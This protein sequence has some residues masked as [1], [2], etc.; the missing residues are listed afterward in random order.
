MTRRRQQRMRAIPNKVLIHQA[1]R[2]ESEDDHPDT[3]R[4]VRL[5]DLWVASSG[6]T[7]LMAIVSLFG[8]DT[9]WAV[10][11]MPL[12]VA[13]MTTVLAPTQEVEN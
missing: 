9:N 5:I 1:Y 3:V 6:L 4:V 12:V 13:L 10:V 2:D 7:A 11:F 8:E